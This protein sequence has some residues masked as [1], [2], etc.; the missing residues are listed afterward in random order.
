MNAREALTQ[1]LVA[2]H[3]AMQT[4]H[5]CD[6]EQALRADELFLPDEQAAVRQACRMLGFV[7]ED[8]RLL[9]QAWQRQSQRTGHFDPTHWPDSAQDFGLVPWPR[10]N[11][12]APCP[13]HLGLYAVLPDAAWIARMAQAGVP[14]VQLRFKSTDQEAVRREVRTAVQAVKGTSS[15]LFI[16]DHWK[17]A[18]EEGAYGVHLGQ[19]DMDEAQ[20]ETIRQAGLRLGLSTHGYGELLRAQAVSPSYL[21]LGA[22]FPTT[23]KKMKTAPQGLGRLGAYARLMKGRSLVAIGGI[24][25]NAVPDVMRTGVG[26]IAVVRAITA[27]EQP[28]QAAL[29][30]QQAM[31]LS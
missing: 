28:D 5:S 9:D 2:R 23:L 7:E 14:T 17:I 4:E 20:L 11:A 19:E 10:N 27:A 29:A 18:I 6:F 16:N 12:F 22:V 15:L 26:S 3:A 21:A 8:A 13:E 25:L 30:F 1:A 24:D 31:K